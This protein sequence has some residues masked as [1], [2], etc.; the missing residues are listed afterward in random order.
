MEVHVT[1]SH[2]KVELTEFFQGVACARQSVLLLDYDGTLAPFQLDR[3]QAV[4]YHGVTTLLQA[5]MNTGRTRLAMITGRRA[6]ELV[7]LLKLS[8]PPEI[9]G[10]HGWEHLTAEGAY[11]LWPLEQSAQDGLREGG[12]RLDELGLAAR[13]EDKP[14]SV[15]VP[16]A[17]AVQRRGRRDPQQGDGGVVA[18]RCELVP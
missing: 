10:S 18:A 17:W 2:S 9:W 1:D 7:P 6:S 16:L 4:P 12:L 14:V 13:R 8:P 3:Y 15:A 11:E 5:I